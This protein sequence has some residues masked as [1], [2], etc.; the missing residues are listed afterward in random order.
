M[1]LLAAGVLTL[2]VAL[3]A[4]FGGEKEGMADN[5]WYVHW[6][7]FKPGTIVVHSEETVFG[8]DAK[9]EVPGGVDRK[10]VRYKLLEVTP[11]RVVVETVVTEKDFLSSIQAAPT[12]I[13]Y[14]AKVNKANLASLLVSANA[15]HGEETVQVRLGDEDKQI[16][17]KTL[18]GMRKKK[19]EEVRQQYW[20]STDVPGGVVKR[21]RTTTHEGALV[22]KTTILLKGYK[23]AE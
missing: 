14:P 7:N 3:P 13:I 18:T 23:V 16:K 9:D 20:Y 15:K 12:K 22:A 5:P 11:K 21:I 19:G 6:A 10:T 1:C 2:A 4:G 17:C 8:D